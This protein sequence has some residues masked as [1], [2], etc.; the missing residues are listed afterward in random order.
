M[1]TLMCAE[2]GYNTKDMTEFTNHAKSHEE[3]TVRIEPSTLPSSNLATMLPMQFNQFHL[4]QI[5]QMLKSIQTPPVTQPN[6]FSVNN[7]FDVMRL[8]AQRTP[9]QSQEV[10]SDIMEVRD[11]EV[12]KESSPELHQGIKKSKKQVHSCPHCNF[13]TVMSQHM[14]AHV[15]A[16]IKHQGSMYM[17]DVCK[18]Q[19]SQKANMHRHRMRHSGEKPYECKYCQKKFFRKDQMQEHSMTHIKTGENFD[20]PVNGCPRRF[21]QHQELRNHLTDEHIITAQEQAACKRCAMTFS[22][23]RRILLHYQTKHDDNLTGANRELALLQQGDFSDEDSLS[24]SPPTQAK[25]L[26]MNPALSSLLQFTQLN[27]IPTS[28]A[29]P[30]LAQPGPLANNMNDIMN[31]FSWNPLN[32]GIKRELN[33][34]VNQLTLNGS[35]TTQS[36]PKMLPK[37]KSPLIKM[38][39]EGN[40][41]GN[42]TNMLSKLIEEMKQ[43]QPQLWSQTRSDDH[44]S[45]H[46]PTSGSRASS[47]PQPND[48]EDYKHRI[49]AEANISAGVRQECEHCGITFNDDVMYILHKKLHSEENPWKCGLCEKQCSDKISFATHIV[50]DGHRV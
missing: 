34:N 31:N 38:E 20:C 11:E 46:S 40:E 14:K 22:N 39:G 2:C 4:A 24:S 45:T 13:S 9:E 6:V 41:V 3:S 8:L 12:K 47:S 42:N 25:P 33:V 49:E 15:E 36:S 37:S 44:S 28:A 23:H 7:G 30:F 29:N 17:C 19:F 27:Q 43:T 18:M 26:S 50:H 10:K 35:T 21:K 1:E 32:M 5:S 48:A 16:H